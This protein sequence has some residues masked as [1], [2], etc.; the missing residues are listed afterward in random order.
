MAEPQRDL[1]PELRDHLEDGLRVVG[2][3]D[4]ST[5]NIQ[6][7]RDDVVGAYGDDSIEDVTNDPV[8]DVLGTQQQESRY[9]L[10]DLRA[11]VRLFDDGF[12]VHVPTDSHEDCPV[13]LDEDA[14]LNG[15][16]VA[17][18]VQEAPESDRRRGSRPVDQELRP[19]GRNRRT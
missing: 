19:T 9:E 11:T 18:L 14:A 17:S 10:G 2:I 16:D 6:Y 15:R 8:F 1:A 5:W 3:H 13:S 12:V 7:I 4:E